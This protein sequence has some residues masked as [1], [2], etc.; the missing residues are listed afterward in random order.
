MRPSAVT[1]VASTII[2]AVPPTARLPRWTRCQSLA[3]PSW[4]EYSHIGDMAIRLRKVTSRI[5]NG[6]N[7][8]ISVRPGRD[9]YWPDLRASEPYGLIIR[10]VGHGLT[11]G[12]WFGLCFHRVVLS[13]LL[14]FRRRWPAGPGRTILGLLKTIRGAKVFATSRMKALAEAE[15]MRL[16]QLKG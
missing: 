8:S 12:I 16:G 2:K 3:K 6:L 7:K 9:Q 13:W 15:E 5:V 14:V 10:P 1:A 4:A 11:H